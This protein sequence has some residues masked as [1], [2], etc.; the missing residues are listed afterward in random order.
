ME[1]IQPQGAMRVDGGNE[2]EFTWWDFVL[3][4]W[5]KRKCCVCEKFG[6]CGHREPKAESL[7]E[8]EAVRR[9]IQQRPATIRRREVA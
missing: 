3:D 8:Y 5:A 9:R 6:Q 7:L 1:R 4:K 2:V